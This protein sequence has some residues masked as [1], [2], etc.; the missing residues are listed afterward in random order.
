[1]RI[2][3]LRIYILYLLVQIEAILNS[4]PLTPLSSDPSDLR[5]LTPGHFLV[6][7]PLTALPTPTLIDVN[8]H[9][10]TRF[11]RLEKIRQEFWQRWNKEYL[12]ELQQRTKWRT[13]KGQLQEGTL[14]LIKED[15][16]PP[17]KWSLGRITKVY[18][19]TDGVTRV[20]DLKTSRGIVRRAFNRI[21]PLPIEDA[22]LGVERQAFQR[23]GAC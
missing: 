4:R 22:T 6:G 23:R 7:R 11:E 20:A 8:E 3:Y 19:G 15:S 18:P 2:W 12:S 21:C 14:A 5:P 13:S 16:L 10:L 9:R 17:M 1:M